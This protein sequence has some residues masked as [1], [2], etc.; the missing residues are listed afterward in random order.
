MQWL[1]INADFVHAFSLENVGLLMEHQV[2]K[3][4]HSHSQLALKAV[5][6]QC[7]HEYL[8]TQEMSNAETSSRLDQLV[9]WLMST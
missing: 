4:I 8:I 2:E 7:W 3:C 6:V 1:L 9:Q 5:R